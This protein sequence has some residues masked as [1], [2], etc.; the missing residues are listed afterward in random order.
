MKVVRAEKKSG[1]EEAR[2]KLNHRK[3]WR[4]QCSPQVYQVI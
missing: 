2:Y 4:Y 3:K 1:R